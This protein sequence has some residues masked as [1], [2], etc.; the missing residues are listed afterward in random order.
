MLIG[1]SLISSVFVVVAFLLGKYFSPAKHSV[2]TVDVINKNKKPAANE[3]Y[4]ACRMDGVPVMF[5]VDAISKAAYRAKKNPE[6][7]PNI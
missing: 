5:S 6:D 1:F 4:K 7:W 3:K 2:K